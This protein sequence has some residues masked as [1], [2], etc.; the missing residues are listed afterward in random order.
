M[1]MCGAERRGGRCGAGGGAVTSLVLAQDRTYD[2]D[3]NDVAAVICEGSKVKK[4]KKKA[5][6]G[7]NIQPAVSCPLSRI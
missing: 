3:L 7:K 2:Y 4:K 6:Q 5:I 1:N